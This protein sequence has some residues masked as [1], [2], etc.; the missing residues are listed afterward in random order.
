MELWQRDIVTDTIWLHHD[1]RCYYCDHRIDTSQTIDH[2][3]PKS[4]YPAESLTW[5]N[6]LPSLSNINSKK[7]T[8]ELPLDPRHIASDLFALQLRNMTTVVRDNS[9]P[10]ASVAR[11]MLIVLG[12]DR[13]DWQL[14]KMRRRAI[15]LFSHKQDRTA[16]TAQLRETSPFLMDELIRQEFCTATGELLELGQAWKKDFPIVADGDPSPNPLGA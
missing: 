8:R 11:D 4:L 9:H 6:Y 15:Q 16:A 7:G 12:L 14:T 1:L 2:I 10:L 13:R 3:R 5:A